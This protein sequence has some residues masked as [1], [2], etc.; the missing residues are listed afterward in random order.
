MRLTTPTR[1]EFTSYSQP[2]A[3][4]TFYWVLRY[5]MGLAPFTGT[6]FALTG[7]T[8]DSGRAYSDYRTMAGT[9]TDNRFLTLAN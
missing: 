4:R 2:I 5:G 9:C 8:I 7:T 3:W 1:M 6:T